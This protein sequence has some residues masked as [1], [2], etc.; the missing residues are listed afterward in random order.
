MKVRYAPTALSLTAFTLELPI[1]PFGIAQDSTK[2]RC[3]FKSVRL[4]GF[5]MWGNYVPGVS[6]KENTISATCNP[7]RT[8]RPIEWADTSCYGYT[9]H[10]SKKFRKDEPL[11][12]WFLT[13]AGETN[14]EISFVLPQGAL[15]EL[16]FQYV[17]SDG[18]EATEA[19]SSGLTQG[20]VYTN[21]LS[22][23]LTAL[24]RVQSK[25]IV[26]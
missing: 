21:Q 14:P 13:A 2:L 1:V 16:T 5:E 24:S 11:G 22:T 8:V 12:L 17:L 4:A 3:P 18:E 25:V 23:D 19:S 9:A 10:I 20:K 6:I 7:R 26:I 15:L